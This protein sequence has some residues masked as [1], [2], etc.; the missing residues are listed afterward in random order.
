MADYLFYWRYGKVET[1]LEDPL[2]II[3]SSADLELTDI[4]TH[5]EENSVY[6]SWY[7][8][9]GTGGDGTEDFPYRT[10]QYARDMMDSG[11][12][13][14]TILDSN[15]YYTG[16]GIDLYFDLDGIILQGAEGQTPTL[17][18]NT[19]IAN[20]ITMIRLQN[21][22]KIINCEIQVDEE[23]DEQTTAIDARDGEIKNVTINAA[24][25]YGIQKTTAGQVDITNCIIKNSVND[26]VID[27]SGITISEGTLNIEYCQITGNDYA[28]LICTGTSSKTIT[29]DYCTIA[30]NQYGIKTSG[31]SNVDLSIFNSIIY[32]NKIYDHYGDDGEYEYTC[33][34]KVQG[35][36]TLSTTTSILR[37]NPLFIGEGDYNIRSKYNGYGDS[38]ML[39]PCLGISEDLIDLG[40]YQ[41]TRTLSSIDYTSFTTS[42]P[43]TFSKSK[44]AIDAKLITVKSL[45]SKLL[46]RGIVNKIDLQ[47]NGNDNVLTENEYNNLGLLFEFE[48]NVYLSIDEGET[49]SQY[50]ID[51]TRGFRGDRCL[52]IQDNMLH[53]NVSLTLYET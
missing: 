27:G 24:N 15:Y 31:S 10:I 53:T 45:K 8:D 34:G 9:D 14:I 40:C 41:Y 30:D 2:H 18:I 28:G 25:K 26:G 43:L 4:E 29:I 1:W 36:P 5:S 35:S 11:Q 39:S 22:G 19:A 33:I 51:K 32:K 3:G 7:G 46:S 20:Q 47:W 6:V 44:I 49:Y 37:I 16:D 13:I 21:G 48:G 23:Y 12:T 42:P 17:R 52:I 38:L 50:E